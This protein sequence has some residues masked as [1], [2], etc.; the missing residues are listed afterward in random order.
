MPRVKKE[1]MVGRRREQRPDCRLLDA[2]FRTLEAAVY[3]MR[4]EMARLREEIAY[5]GYTRDQAA[6][7][8]HSGARRTC[9]WQKLFRCS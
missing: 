3:E 1:D 6:A 9:W 7:T 4:Q 8:A 5:L 2:G